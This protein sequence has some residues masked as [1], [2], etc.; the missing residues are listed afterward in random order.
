MAAKLEKKEEAYAPRFY[1]AVA[2]R[3]T[4]VA[5]RA[6]ARLRADLGDYY[7]RPAFPGRA[8]A[9]LRVDYGLK[10]KRMEFRYV[11]NNIVIRKW[12]T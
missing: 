1:P 9:R 2:G 10:R 4:A 11:R 5:G 7:S 8:H 6:H 3:V 12:R